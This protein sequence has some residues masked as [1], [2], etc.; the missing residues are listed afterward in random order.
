[1]NDGYNYFQVNY[2]FLIVIYININIKMSKFDS[3]PNFQTKKFAF[4]N[5]FHIISHAIKI[6]YYFLLMEDIS[7]NAT[8]S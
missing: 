5:K 2:N 3:N 6:Q 4:L 1:M 7:L 8:L